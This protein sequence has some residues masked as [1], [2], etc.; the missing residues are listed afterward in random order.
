MDVAYYGKQGQLPYKQTRNETTL[1]PLA[2]EKEK[3]FVAVQSKSHAE[4]EDDNFLSQFPVT[5]T[6][7]IGSSLKFC[8]VAEGT[9]D[10]YYRNGPTSEWDTAAGH[11]LVLCSGGRVLCDEQ[12]LPYNKEF[13]RNGSFLC[14]QNDSMLTYLES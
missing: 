8:L 1:L 14:I 9:A 3:R 2:I 7:S 5:E 11:A 12:E 10:I 13:L 4:P 6:I